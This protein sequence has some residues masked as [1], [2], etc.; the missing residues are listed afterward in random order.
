[1]GVFQHEANLYAKGSNGGGVVVPV[2]ANEK[3]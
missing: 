3:E 2:Q 1:M